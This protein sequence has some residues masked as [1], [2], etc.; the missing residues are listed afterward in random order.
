LCPNTARSML[1]TSEAPEKACTPNQTLIQIL[2]RHARLKN[3]QKLNLHRQNCSSTHKV[4]RSPHA[5]DASSDDWIAYM[6]ARCTARVEEH[7]NRANKLRD[8]DGQDG[9]PVVETDTDQTRTQ[10]PVTKR[11]GEVEDD[12]V[13]PYT[14]IR[15]PYSGLSKGVLTPPSA[16]LGWCWVKIHVRPCLARFSI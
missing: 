14:S 1:A 8:E 5:E 2:V 16:L 15:H 3:G 4:V 11:Q 6:I 13:V 7:G 9:L 12:I 10:G